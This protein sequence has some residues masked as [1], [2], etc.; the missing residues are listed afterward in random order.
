[1]FEVSS[2]ELAQLEEL[3][4]SAAKAHVRRRATGLWNLAQG[5]SVAEVAA[6]LN[7]YPTTVYDWRQRFVEEGIGG[8]SL[9]PGRGRPARAQGEEIEAYLRQSPRNFG[10]NRTRWTLADLARVVPSLKDFTPSGVWRA[11]RRC[12]LSFKRGQPL[13]HSPDPAYIQKRALADSAS[14]SRRQS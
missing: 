7:V 3:M 12:G 10:L 13:I 4:R 5:R 9:K 14:G 1:M 8:L 2:S 11:L 6:F